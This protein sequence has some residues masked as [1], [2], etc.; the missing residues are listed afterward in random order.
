MEDIPPEELNSRLAIFFI[1]V[2][3]LNGN[4]FEPGTLTSFQPLVSA[5]INDNTE[6]IEYRS[7]TSSKALGLTIDE[8]EKFCNEKKV[9]DHS[10]E[11]LLRTVWLNNTMQ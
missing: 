11:A 10:S 9:G 8:L 7:V 2:K 3:K 4:E 6:R 5:A 1:K